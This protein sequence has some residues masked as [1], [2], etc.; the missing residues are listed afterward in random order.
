MSR[1][2]SG[3]LWAFRNY[4]AGKVSLESLRKKYPDSNLYINVDEEGDHE[5]YI[6]VAKELDATYSKNSFQ[7]GYCGDFGDVNVGRGCWPKEY[8]FEWVRG[9]YEACIKDDAE[10]MMLLEEDDFILDNISLLGG[11]K[12]SMAIHPTNPSPTGR[13]RPN[14]IPKPFNDFILKNGGK[15]Y[16]GYAAGGGTIFNR[17]RF[18][19]SWKTNKDLIWEN[20]DD[21]VK[22]SK[23]IG[24]AD[25]ILQFIMQL[26]GYTI[27]QND[28]LAEHWE[29]G[30]RWNEFE[31]I[32]GMKDLELVKTAL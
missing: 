6:K 22:V 19:R 10:Y 18:I 4:Q 1:K 2:I 14:P 16:N 31:I 21:L 28:R 20:Y 32:T 26:Q 30:D 29:V 7:L 13:M 15:L 5:N 24:W 27:I 9:I 12:F 11:E 25:Y 17:A 3:Y 23:I 8:T